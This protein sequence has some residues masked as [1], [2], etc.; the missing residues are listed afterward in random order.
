MTENSILLFILVVIVIMLAFA[1]AVIW[2][3]NN[4]Q[5]KITQ[6]KLNEQEK[7]LQFQKDLLSNTVKIQEEERTRISAELHDDVTS[8]L[9]V[10]HLNMHLLKQQLKSNN[11]MEIF[12]EQIEASLK[13]SIDRSRSIAHELMPVVLRKFGLLH[14]LDDLTNSINLSEI[15]DLT[16][17]GTEQLK[18]KDDF[19]SL[20]IFRIIQELLNNAIKYSK[21]EK[22][23]LTFQ[24]E[25]EDIIMKYTD[26]GIGIDSKVDTTGL[27][28]G[29]IN[30]RIRLLG[31]EMVIDPSTHTKGLTIHFKFPNHDQI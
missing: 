19:K 17:K 26:D 21:A 10:V 13:A 31:G 22:V 28:F 23:N 27:G 25:Q 12:V 30:T 2:F 16:I 7:E 14:A 3:L 11:E 15:F 29:N 18:I 9:N 20:N 1:V 5:K 6:A 24:E 8:K 4:S